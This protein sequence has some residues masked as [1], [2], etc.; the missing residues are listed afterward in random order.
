MAASLVTTSRT[1]GQLRAMLARIAQAA[2]QIAACYERFGPDQPWG[3]AD[4]TGWKCSERFC[5]AWQ[6]C[7]G[8]LGL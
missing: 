8:G 3:F 6:A 1:P 7:P 4:P 5:P 2:G